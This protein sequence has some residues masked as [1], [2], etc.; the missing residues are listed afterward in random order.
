MSQG[1]RIAVDEDASSWLKWAAGEFPA[2]MK[3]A[4]KSTGWMMQKATK[5]GI[6][7]GAP[8]G[9]TYASFMSASRRRKLGK[10]VSRVPLGKL[11]RAI[12]YQ[13]REEEGAVYVGWLSP[14]A[15][16]LGYKLQNGFTGKVSPK[17][18]RFFFYRGLGM[19]KNATIDIPPRP[20]ID[21]MFA[22]L[23]PQIPKYLEGKLWE[24][25]RDGKGYK[26]SARKYRV[27][28]Q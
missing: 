27:F 2:L 25:L 23:E 10:S 3:R 9:K 28:G 16:S 1:L 24:Y 5:E 22:Q 13:Y 11:G 8:G 6:R 12:G 21:P 7:K 15:A 14:S 17:M 18:R 26:R 19:A 4:L 20:T